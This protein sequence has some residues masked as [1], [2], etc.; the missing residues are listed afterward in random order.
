MILAGISQVTVNASATLATM[1][2]TL[3]NNLKRLTL[4]PNGTVNWAYGGA[5]ASSSSAPVPSSGIDFPIDAGNARQLQFY[6]S[7]VSMVVLA[8]V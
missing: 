2:V 8:F 3:P 4:I 1:G 5:A 7:A 6:A